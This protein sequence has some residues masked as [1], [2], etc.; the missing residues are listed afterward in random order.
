MARSEVRRRASRG[1]VGDARAL[2]L[3]P[4]GA[5][6]HARRA[7]GP[8]R[9]TGAIGRRCLPWPWQEIPSATPA[10]LPTPPAP[11]GRPCA[12]AFAHSG[13]SE[14][15]GAISNVLLCATSTRCV[16]AP[17]SGSA[18][19][20]FNCGAPARPPS[21]RPRATANARRTTATL[22]A[23]AA[24]FDSP[25]RPSRALPSVDDNWPPAANAPAPV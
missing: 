12:T 24:G 25:P 23:W 1:A 18:T 19:C 17:P 6:A 4:P 7:A 5:R 3:E 11:G 16:D 22:I 15:N 10:P 13:Q 20:K 8:V 9:A 2:M 21:P 14:T